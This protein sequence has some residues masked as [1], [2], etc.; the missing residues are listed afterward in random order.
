[1]RPFEYGDEE[2]GEIE[3][4]YIVAS[5]VIA[6]GILTLPRQLAE[7]TNFFDGW[8]PL[9]IAGGTSIIFTG[10]TAKLAC[11]FPNQSFFSYASSI[12]SKPGS[13][14]IT[15]FLALHFIFL[16]GFETRAVAIVA[17]QYLFDRTPAEVIALAFLLVVVYAV[18]GTRVGIIRLNLLFLPIILFIAFLLMVLNIPFFEVKNLTPLFTTSL[19]GHFKGAKESF[20][21]ISGFAGLLFY[22]SFVNRPKKAPKFAIFGICIAL[23]LYLLF[24][25]MSIGVFSAGTTATLVYP[26][27]ELAKE[28][29]IPG[30]FL[31]RFE[32][33]FFTVWV[34]AIF[35][36]TSLAFDVS[37]M[38]LSSLFQKVKKITFIFVLT[39]IIF[40]IAMFPQNLVEMELLSK[41]LNYSTYGVSI[42]VPT[43]LY[44]L[45]KA[46]RIKG[47]G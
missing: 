3:I 5:Y 35:N 46:R 47:N 26:T 16:S 1:M 15:L 23:G 11:R 36:T 32:S 24:Y 41:Y 28:A 27:I 42:F 10:I 45:A 22:I 21:S 17:K 9:M 19:E 43:G 39:P 7:A 40:M 8:I 18:S 12:C 37:L 14:V 31:G 29:E 4:L 44:V 2:I 25:T 33:L 20:F 34:M 6:Y 38:A 13:V 30:G